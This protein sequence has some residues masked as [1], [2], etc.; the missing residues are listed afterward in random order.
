VVSQESKVIK[1]VSRPGQ[2]EVFPRRQGEPGLGDQ[3]V[4]THDVYRDDERVGFDGGVCTVVRIDDDGTRHILCTVNMSLPEGTL[5]F[6][7]FMP[8]TFPPPPFYTAVTGGTGAYA[9]A[10]GEMHI[11]PA[12]PDTHYYT[13]HLEGTG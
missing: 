8:E 4:F 6:Q 1:L 12:S 7:T 2:R 13:I 10:R 3:S 9:G 5:T 11:D